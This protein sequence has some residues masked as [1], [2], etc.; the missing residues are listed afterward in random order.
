MGS[1]TDE[2][3]DGLF[4]EQ[5]VARG[6]HLAVVDPANRQAL[7]GSDPRRVTW[8][9]LDSEVT[10]LAAKL[11]DLGLKRGSILG[12]Q[13]PNSIELVEVYLAAWSIGVIVSPLAMQYREYEVAT[14]AGAGK[15]EVLVTTSRFGDRNPAQSVISVRE[16]IPTLR[17][18][19]AFGVDEEGR[20]HDSDDIVPVDP[21]AATDADRARVADVRAAD[22]NDPNDCVTI[23]WTS[24]TESAPKGV[25]RTHYDWLAFSW[26]TLDAPR[27]V[28]DDVLLNP[29]P[30]INMAGINGIFL[31]WLRSG[32]TLVQHH[33]FDAPTYF[34]QIAK[35]RVT[36]TLAPPALLWQLLNNEELLAK[37]DLSSLTRMGSGSAPLQPAMVTGW[38]E[39]FGI[40][41]INFFGSNEGVGLLSSVEDFPEPEIRAT[42]FPNY[43]APGVTWSARSSE[44]VE[45]KLVD[46][47]GDVV[48][49]PGIPGELY[50]RGPMVFPG[51]LNGETLPDP[52]DDEDYFRTGDIFEIAGDDNQ[53]LRYL[54]RGKDLVI[55]GGMNIAPAEL[56]S[57]IS[58]HP[59][60]VEVAVVGDPDTVMGERVAVVVVPKPG[61]EITLEDVVALLKERKVASYK[62]PERLEIRESLPRNPLGKILKR[63]LRRDTQPVQ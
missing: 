31:P 36:Y 3:L 58:A 52:F 30:M 53:Y 45:L 49:E 51:Y 9:E 28:A 1:W 20:S 18:V 13:L 40:G 60:I 17:L 32:A 25:P 44:W 63:E 16:Q 15:F 46:G 6:D 33:P 39:R 26:V 12:V 55:R 14:M 7:M 48:T 29:F 24:G 8:Q 56:E 54:D 59:D 38:Q 2:T 27:V 62:L 61:K 41:V 23:C 42:Y 50:I 34:G 10:A 57:L 22:P 37:V 4:A 35:E 21:R 19:V 5:V 43:G 11:L 47:A